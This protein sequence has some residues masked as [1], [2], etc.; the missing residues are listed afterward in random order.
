MLIESAERVRRRGAADG[1]GAGRG[2]LFAHQRAPFAHVHS[3][4]AVRLGSTPRR[5]EPYLLKFLDDHRRRRRRPLPVLGG[6]SFCR[7]R[8]RRRHRVPRVVQQ[9]RRPP[10]LGPGGTLLTSPRVP[11]RRGGGPMRRDDHGRPSRRA[12][13]LRRVGT[14]RPWPCDRVRRTCGAGGPHVSRVGRFCYTCVTSMF[15]PRVQCEY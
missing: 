7:Q 11:E 6:A 9:P 14:E 8:R 4:K 12:P 1:R 5:A 3:H 10:R 13:A 15:T 2:Q